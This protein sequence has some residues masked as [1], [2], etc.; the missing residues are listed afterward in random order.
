MVKAVEIKNLSKS[1]R[2]V[3][4][5]NNVSFSI[6]EGDFFGYLGPNGAGKTTTIG[7]ITGLVN[8]DKGKINV[9]GKDVVRDYKETRQLIGLSQQEFVFDPFLSTID[10]L[11]YH[12][13]YFGLNRRDAISKAEELLKFFDLSSRAGD[14]FRKL[15][16]GMKRRVQIAKALVHDP[17][18]LILD[19]PTSGTDLELRH[20]IWKWLS[21]LNREGKT[22]I[23]TT[24]Y[25]EEAEKLCGKIGIINKGEIAV[26]DKK[27]KL[28]A[29][30]SRQKILFTLKSEAKRIPKINHSVYRKEKKELEV[31]C[32]N[33]QAELPKIMNLLNNAKIKVDDINIVSDKLED[34]YLKVVGEKNAFNGI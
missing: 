1:F 14:S 15:S 10:A 28:L 31:I 18:I 12:G 22:I 29:D 25:I 30:L 32:R 19:E 2:K 4:A 33:A 34:V 7:C 6:E 9:F 20:S 27:E 17:P 23:L 13:G 5:L 26:L 3:K 21:K 24:H 11:T 8:F 16:G